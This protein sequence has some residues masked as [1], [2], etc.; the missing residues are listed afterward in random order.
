MG[1]K[2]VDMILTVAIILTVLTGFF[3]KLVYDAQQDPNLSAYAGLLGLLIVIII[4]GTV[5]YVWD[6]F[7]HSGKK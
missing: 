3:V 4:I 7:S 2:F 1:G 6:T 5:K